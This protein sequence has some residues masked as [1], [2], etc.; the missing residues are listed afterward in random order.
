M[1]PDT[2]S[3]KYTVLYVD[4]E[5]FLLEPTKLFLE[6][7]GDIVLETSNSGTRALELIEKKQY[8]AIIADYQMK[9]INGIDLLKKLRLSGSRIPFIIFTGRGREEVIIEALNSGA[10]FYLQKGHDVHAQYTELHGK[11]IRSIQQRKT[12]EKLRISEERLRLSLMAT[13]QGLWDIHIPTGAISANEVYY[14]ILGYKPEEVNVTYSWWMSQIHPNDREKV[15]QSYSDYLSGKSEIYSIEFRFRTKNGIWIWILSRGRI[16]SY[17]QNGKPLRMIGTHIDITEQ[18][19]LIHQVQVSEERFHLTMTAVNEGVWDWNIQTRTAYFSPQYY[20][21]VG[22]EPDEFPSTYE[23]WKE[24]IHPEERELTEKKVSLALSKNESGFQVRFRFRCKDG[25]YIWILGKGKVIEKDQN[26]K[27][28][29]I[30]GTHTDIT[31]QVDAENQLL[32][33]HQEL[34]QSYEQIAQSEEE[35]RQSEKE[36]T[37]ALEQVQKNFAELSI[38][39][40]GIRNPLTVITAQ[41]ELNCPEIAD[42]V[43][44]QAREIDNLITQLD[45]RW[46]QSEK[47]LNYIRKHHGFDYSN[48]PHEEY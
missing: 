6:H 35:L 21:M 11:V 23:A 38:L 43:I 15:Q 27:P 10:D 22:Y 44:K 48:I 12:E 19:R 17:D 20:Q 3:E 46:I 2:L 9:E 39:N 14:Q 16:L 24:H 41:V 13:N 45:R 47:V 8:D 42:A 29:R 30:V 34:L 32:L 33:K 40:D 7:F 4:D 18:K 37:M 28:I 1:T 5:D 26:G 25:S 31:E 36:R